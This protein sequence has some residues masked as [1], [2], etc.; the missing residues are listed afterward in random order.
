MKLKEW[1][2]ID[3]TF[4][5]IDEKKK[6]AKIVLKY[7]KPEDILD[8]TCVS[9]IPLLRLETLGY[10][11]NIF[12]KVSP[13]Y[14][15]DLT[16]RF[17]DFSD[18]T[19]EQLVDILKKNMAIEL[20]SRMSASRSRDKLAYS[21][22]AAGVLSFLLMF[23]VRCVWNSETVWNELFFYLFDIITT[24]SLYQAVTILGL[25]RK[26]KLAVVKN[27]HDSFSAIHFEIG[28]RKPMPGLSQ[29]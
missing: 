13:K 5:E 15:V 8:R 7:E 11:R 20:K 6:I 16:L 19:E 9:E 1:E 23:L 17:D 27:L 28:E 22:I 18:Y 24:V 12:G 10:F 21:F 2:R 26:E 4:F 25:E 29:Q 3:D 14:K